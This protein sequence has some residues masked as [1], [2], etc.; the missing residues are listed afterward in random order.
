MSRRP[1]SYSVLRYV[2]DIVTGEF[3]NV[4]IVFFAPGQGVD[5]PIVRSEFKERIKRIRPLFY[6]LDRAAFASAISAVRRASKVVAKQVE[7]DLLFSSGD[8]RAIALRMLPHD[9]SSLQWSEIGTGIA[10]DI[11]KEFNRI[12]DRMLSIYDRRTENRKTDED[13]WRPVRQAL[14]DRKVPIEFESKVIRGSV[15]TI[16][17]THS[18]KNGRIHAYEPLS[19][20]LVDAENIKNKARRWMG[21]LSSVNIGASDE[22]KA[23]FI[24]G[25]PSDERLMTA[26][27]A[28]LEILRA[29]PSAPEVY[30]EGD[31][32]KLVNSIEDEFKAHQDA[33]KPGRASL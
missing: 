29:A 10:K 2:H 1:Y 12:A 30:E 16:E 25:R 5:A 13:V 9:G 7:A 23:Y 8:A 21:H 18:W 6:D 11:D 15:D 27:H 32:E 20:D 26:Y 28:A 3:V 4:G 22:F 31:V 14:V 17:F 24:A 19:F 33:V